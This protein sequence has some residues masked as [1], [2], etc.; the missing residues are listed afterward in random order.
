MGQK[1]QYG[2]YYLG[3]DI[4]TESVGWAVTNPDYR[5]LKFGP[6][7]MWGS[8]L[9]PLAK[10]SVERRTYRIARRR[11]QRKNQRLGLLQ[12][13]FKDEI[14]KIDPQFFVR[15]NESM[16]HE[17]HKSVKDKNS[18]FADAGFDD[19][20]Y[21]KAYPTIYHL[22][23][24]LLHSCEPH[25]IRLVYLAIH[26][27]IKYRG[28]FLFQGTLD[29]ATDFESMIQSL[30]D[31]LINNLDKDLS[32][33]SY[34]EMKNIL[35]NR[36]MTKTDKQKKLFS[37]CG[38]TQKSPVG[39]LLKLITGSKVGI[40]DIFP[41]ENM[42]ADSEEDIKVDF[43]S[44]E[45]EQNSSKFEALLS[46]DYIILEKAK[47]IHD[48]MLLE[49]I[50]HDQEYLSDAKIDIYE[51]HAKDLA[52]LKKIIRQYKPDAYNQIFKNPSVKNNY[53]AYAGVAKV[54]R[55]KVSIEKRCTQADFNKYVQSILRD[56]TA[57]DPELEAVK[58][59]LA[60]GTFMPK[61]RTKDNGII[62]NQLQFKELKQ[63]LK[64][65]SEYLP[66][67]QE[68]DQDGISV[69][70]KIEQILTFRIPYYVG[71]LNDRD[72]NANNTWVVRRSH[73]KV[74]PWNFDEIV[75]R[76]QSAT[77]FITRMTAQ[78]TYLINQP[79]LPQNSL[80]YS[81]FMVLN[82]LNNM[83]IDGEQIPVKLKQ[84]IYTDCFEKGKK[85][86]MNALLNYLK[87][88]GYN[89]SK[90]QITGI[91]GGFHTSLKMWSDMRSLLGDKFQIS[92][93][94][95]IIR[96]STVLGEDKAMFRRQLKMELGNALSEEVISKAANIRCTGWGRLSEKLLT[97]IYDRYSY[98]D[99]LEPRNII[100]ALWETN[101]NLMQ[102]LGG[103]HGYAQ[104]I[105]KY[106]AQLEGVS[107]FTYNTVRDLYVSPSVKRS[108]WQALQLVKEIR[109]ITGHDPQKVF[110]EM[111]RGGGEKNVRKESRKTNLVALFKAC[112]DETRDW[113]SELNAHDDSEYRSDKLYLYYTQMGKCMY[114]GEEIDLNR[115]FDQNVYDIDHIYPRSKIKDDSL[116]NRVLVRKDV[117]SK[118]TDAYPIQKDIREKMHSFWAVLL[119]KGFISQKKY[120][121]LVRGNELTDDELSDFV[122]RQLVE[123]RQSTKMVADLLKQLLPDTDI[124]Y[125]KANLVSEFR[126]NYDML[127]CRE[128]ND[129][130]HGKDAYL[131]IVVGNVYHTKFTK[132]PRNFFR[133]KDHTYSLN[134][135]FDYPVKRGHCVAWIPGSEG[136]LHVVQ[137]M[138]NKN[139]VLV[140]EMV[141]DYSGQ[142]FD[143]QPVKKQV[144][145]MPLK[146]KEHFLDRE[147]YGGYKKVKGAYFM[148][149]EHTE[150]GKVKR[151]IIEFPLYLA[152]QKTNE[153]M[154]CKLL[155]DE[156]GLVN[157]KVL[158]P[159]IGICSV[160]EIDGC[161]MYLRGRT[162]NNLDYTLAHQLIL[163]YENE[164]YIRNIMK[165]CDRAAEYK[166]THNKGEL[167]A[168]NNDHISVEENIEMYDLFVQKLKTPIYSV[169]LSA[170]ITNLLKAREQFIELSI[171]KQCMVLK[172]I[173]NL[174]ASNKVTSD[175]S[176]IGL[177][178]QL[179]S[180]RTSRCITNYTKV[181]LIS[182]S[183]TGLFETK[184]NLLL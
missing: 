76:E 17:E 108:I 104:E 70:S 172:Q 156:K 68:T 113:I 87:S 145:E 118:K 141:Q 181:Y 122:A 148:L 28:H 11:T 74:Y 71:P 99:A 1:R 180:I 72:P 132:D 60:A 13:L 178:S 164:I 80:V 98:N 24:E 136:S 50:L 154:I 73:E 5:L 126:Q 83:R 93:A 86:T 36:S 8:R 44:D 10:T 64:N 3:L 41:G 158:I 82:E 131:N 62:P 46:D 142:L 134:R 30:N 171:E 130:H 150:K 157:P 95:T 42:P 25:D 161:R 19:K 85:V 94:E 12:D 51:Q 105:E 174:F 4:G 23:K 155:A 32:C 149:V 40:W 106:N 114:T 115:L 39:M 111:A 2:D 116:D 75:D 6:K 31:D 163:G 169:R 97:Q 123:T 63:I 109:K 43:E 53:C 184:R 90:D 21:H 173:L 89:I 77:R 182:Q 175:L 139:N 15:L 127:K 57:T 29:S 168:G 179:G 52:Q 166:K 167:L 56:V 100:T 177:G 20:A 138:M 59:R 153:E 160:I 133:E 16:L 128:V 124:V 125:V 96:L 102:L 107:D 78:C 27:I 22:R 121:R 37:L 81:R 119:Q 65:A 88:R 58:T 66:F 48:W 34:D 79:V 165:F 9:F 162:G 176:E 33:S 159:H 49:G 26:H 135:M 91:D 92:I 55:K 147:K 84:D 170:Q 47:A 120:D 54:K 144:W 7:A 146:Q 18:L 151:S 183:V 129:L 112:R 110:I 38:C 152:N 35:S 117:N 140:T 67:L 45:Y 101:E 103:D 69:S 137:E 143:V 14:C 61:L